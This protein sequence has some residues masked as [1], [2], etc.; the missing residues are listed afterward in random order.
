MNTPRTDAAFIEAAY[1]EDDEYAG[2]VM[3]YDIGKIKQRMQ[4][5]ESENIRLRECLQSAVECL[6]SKQMNGAML[7]LQNHGMPW[8]GPV[9][10]M[11]KARA[12]LAETEAK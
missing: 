9:F 3:A 4:K 1:Q 10:D 2:T 7:M 11:D 12:L 5:L 6:G 8:N